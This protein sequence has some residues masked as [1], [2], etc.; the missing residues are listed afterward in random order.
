MSACACVRACVCLCGCVRASEGAHV[1]VW[2]NKC[3]GA[4]ANAL[5]GARTCGCACEYYASSRLVR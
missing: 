5:E 2:V 4:H 3:V 1:S